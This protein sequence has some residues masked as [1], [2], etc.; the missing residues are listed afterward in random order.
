MGIF[1]N[2]FFSLK[3]QKE[4]LANVG[5][6]LKAV[7][8]NVGSV[9]GLSKAQNISANVSSPL[10]KK[11]LELVA[12]NPFK[13]AAVAGTAANI[14]K[15][16]TLIKSSVAKSSA[17][18]AAA[19]ATTVSGIVTKPQNKATGGIITPQATTS[20]PVTAAPVAG[21]GILSPT[22]TSGMLTPSSTRTTRSSGRRRKRKRTTTR[23]RRS[24]APRRSRRSRKKRYGTA[25]QYARPGGKSVKY[26]KGRPYIVRPNGMWRF[27][28]K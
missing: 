24:R 13:T 5:S 23:R 26:W 11:G 25:K 12:N 20:A 27:I 14:P 1:S 18:K 10:L 8:T 17:K 3:G 15:A 19:K 9:F 28:K 16:A 22:Q 21:G 7:A 6:T 2:S 4:R